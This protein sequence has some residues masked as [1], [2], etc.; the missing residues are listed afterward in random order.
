MTTVDA[1]PDVL[2]ACH[3]RHSLTRFVLLAL[4]VASVAIAFGGCRS[5]QSASGGYPGSPHS[6][7]SDLTRPMTLALVDTR[8]SETIWVYEIPAGMRLV[9]TFS[10]GDEPIADAMRP[11]TLAY[12][13]FNSG[14]RAGK[15]SNRLPVPP[16]E[17]RR[18]E[19]FIRPMPELPPLPA[20]ALE[21]DDDEG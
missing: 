9:T 11:D 1:H 10:A 17:A 7:E 16:A 13:V 2:A 15:L 18:W 20:S 6:W 8:T 14:Q 19:V 5:A 3:I 12:D 21:E 4:A